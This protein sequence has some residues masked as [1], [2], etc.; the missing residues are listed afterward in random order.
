MDKS[1]NAH[2]DA[3]NVIMERV[4]YGGTDALKRGEGVCY[5]TDYGT[6]TTAEASRGNRVE[7]PTTSNNMAFAGVAVQNY[8][9]SASGQFI[10]IYVPGSKCVPVALG[11]NT[12]IDTGLLTFG[13]CGLCDIGTDGGDGSDGGR[14]YNGKYKGRG[15]A[16]PRQTVTA[17]LDDG[18]LGLWSLAT[19]GVTL[20]LDGAVST[21]VAGDTIVLLGGEDDGTGCVVP[22]KYTVASVTSTTILVLSSSAVDT[23]PAGALTCTGYAYTGNP[24]AICDLLTGDE[25]GGVEFLNI[26][27]AGVVGM[28]YMVGGLSYVCGNLTLAADVDITFAQGSLSG[29]KKAFILLNDLATS[30]FTLDLATAGYKL[31]GTADLAD[32]ATIDDAGDGCFLEFGGS[33]WNNRGLL[34]G[35]TEA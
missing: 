4:W 7:R 24:T 8:P 10:D 33:K 9:A 35:A 5:N 22:G 30:D 26:P 25:S 28:P 31:A 1:I 13:V 17:L 6:A 19:D 20:T 23:T 16:I 21:I 12:V 27:N 32:I 34:V 3:P 2:I 11:V 15:S 18:S 14:F 29:D